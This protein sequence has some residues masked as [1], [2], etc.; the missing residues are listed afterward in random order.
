[1]EASQPSA[2]AERRGPVVVGY[3]GSAASDQAV[4]E[5]GRLLSGRPA[6]VVVVWKHGLGFE[7]LELPAATVGMPATTL[8]VRSALEIDRELAESAE[9]LARQGA[10]AARAA[11]LDADGLAVADDPDVSIADSIVR[12]ARE[13]DA[14]AIVVGAHDQGVISEVLLGSTSRDV[15]H[16]ADRPVVVVRER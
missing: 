16:R 3:D 1:M 6:L 2:D 9:R 14:Q 10:A 12:V 15:V 11:G 5:A 7:L 4:R 8:D 13:R